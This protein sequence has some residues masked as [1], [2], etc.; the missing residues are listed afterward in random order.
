MDNVY[1]SNDKNVITIGGSGFGLMAILVGINRGFISREEAL[2]RYE[3][4]IQFLERKADR[5]HGAWPHW[6]SPTGKTVPF[7]K[8]DNGEIQWKPHF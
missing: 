3:K 1:P 7:G 6:L 2:V 8:K 5:F 4:A